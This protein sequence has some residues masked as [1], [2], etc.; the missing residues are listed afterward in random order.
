M[1]I[2]SQWTLTALCAWALSRHHLNVAELGLLTLGPA[3]AWG[4]AAALGAV[5]IGATLM[6]VRSLRKGTR[7][8]L[9][10]HLASVAR[11]LPVSALERAAFTPVALTA[12][13]CE[14]TL[15]RGFLTFTFLQL[16]HSMPAA[17]AL[18]TLSF[19]FGHLYQGPRGVLSTTV[20]GAFLA[21]L[22]WGAV[23]LWP[24]V[25]LHAVIDLVNGNALGSLSRLPA[26][27]VEPALTAADASAHTAESTSEFPPLERTTGT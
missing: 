23:S 6:A 4:A 17:L 8:D 1:V 26:A 13:L 11:I 2:V 7:E 18:S 27:A 12:G 5:L 20:L 24:G 9:P 25:V 16:T 3:W 10:P 21:A 14:E 15:Y 22:Y 19:G